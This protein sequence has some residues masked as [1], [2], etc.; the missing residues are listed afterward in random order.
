MVSLTDTMT[1]EQRGRMQLGEQW[2]FLVEVLSRVMEGLA[3][4][5][6]VK[7]THSAF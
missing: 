2:K 5:A 1:S 6:A 4:G 3:G 7:F